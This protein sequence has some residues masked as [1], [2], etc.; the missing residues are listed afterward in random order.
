MPGT[1]ATWA[2]LGSL[3]AAIASTLIN[4][5]DSH[6]R[7]IQ[8]SVAF[9]FEEPPRD[10]NT[11]EAAVR[12]W[13]ETV[14]QESQ[15]ACRAGWGFEGSQ[16]P[17]F[18]S[19]AWTGSLQI[20]AAGIYGPADRGGGAIQATVL[21]Q[22]ENPPSSRPRICWI[23]LSHPRGKVSA[24]LDSFTL[25]PRVAHY[26]PLSKIIQ[27]FW[28]VMKNVC[29]DWVPGHCLV[30]HW[31]KQVGQARAHCVKI[32]ALAVV[33]KHICE[34]NSFI[35]SSATLAATVAFLAK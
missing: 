3:V 7:E 28:F 27:L 14:W 12:C 23:R 17:P 16:N 34:Y 8:F 24:K 35:S 9:M 33:S 32:K 1:H 29:K 2:V 20:K 4:C 13:R 21:Q 6:H 22:A 25:S 10:S 18:G 5:F 11:D 26:P 31:S 15:T 30:S 19:R